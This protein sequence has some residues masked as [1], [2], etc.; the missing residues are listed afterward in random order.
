MGKVALSIDV[1]DWFCVRNMGESISPHDWNQHE[2]RVRIGL[3]FI[4]KEL[5]QRGIKA[6]FFML[7]W[8]AEK[9]P[10]I[11]A[12]LNQAGHEVASHG[13][14]HRPLDEM[15]PLDFR[16]DLKASLSILSSQS[17]TP[18]LGYRAPSFS[19]TED[20]T[21]ALDIM[22]ELGFVYDSS[23]YPIH[24]PN[25]GMPDFP[26][27][28]TRVA[29]ILEL[30]MST[31]NLFGASLPISGGGYFRL[32]PYALS[33]WLIQ[34]AERQGDVILYFHPWEFDEDQPRVKLPAFRRFRHYVGLSRNRAKFRRLLDDFSF[35]PM[36]DLVGATVDTAR[37]NRETYK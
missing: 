23:I 10:S 36:K 15:S 27:G 12:E 31:V 33:K 25:Y 22:R 5:D 24:H 6:T 17:S 30:P 3:D 1:E 2:L 7:A 26:K 13:Y 35:C 16:E 32:Y 21:W 14:N 8:I 28:P 37:A 19:I 29:G 11:V 4:L 34:R 18:I 9:C 20:T